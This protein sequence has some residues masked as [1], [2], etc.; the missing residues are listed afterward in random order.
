MYVCGT[1]TLLRPSTR[2]GVRT[3][4]LP[5]AGVLPHH[6]IGIGSAQSLPSTAKPYSGPYSHAR[7]RTTDAPLAKA[8]GTPL[9]DTYTYRKRPARLLMCTGDVLIPAPAVVRCVLDGTR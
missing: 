9:S 6:S 4:A 1:E 7:T 8:K 2:V 3:L 5:Q